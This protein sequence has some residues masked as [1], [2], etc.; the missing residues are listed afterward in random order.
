MPRTP[1]LSATQLAASG[2]ATV[3]AT[4]GASYLGVA[5]T[6]WGAAFM[7]VASTA[8]VAVYKHYLEEG[9]KQVW[10]KAHTPPEVAETAADITRMDPTRTVVWPAGTHA[11]DP[12]EVI[13]GVRM[14]PGEDP[15]RLLDTPADPTR[16]E[17]TLEWFK[18]RWVVLAASS[19]AVFA[20][21]MGGVTL[22][23][24][25]ADKPVSALVG[26]TDDKGTS[27]GNVG[28][29]GGNTPVE[30]PTDRPTG[31]PTDPPSSRPPQ[32]PNP[33]PTNKPSPPP[34]KPPTQPPTHPPTQP[35]VSPP[36]KQP[37]P[38]TP[39]GDN[40]QAP[41]QQQPLGSS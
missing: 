37:P 31:K 26:A 40:G 3:T 14:E 15:T 32:Q 10:E 9:K 38:E 1:E 19:V 28:D 7:S 30:R 12:T 6:L 25:L 18:Q 13:A 36:A 5:G 4:V 21:V 2:L 41:P 22:V 24:A 23:E 35:P 17:R 8:G 20:V 16:G 34:T 29:K 11:A 33:E 27:F 39:K